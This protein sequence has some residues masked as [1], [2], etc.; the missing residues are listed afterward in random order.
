M[1]A[2]TDI[3][4]IGSEGAELARYE[5][6]SGERVLLGWRQGYGVEVVDRP[7]AGRGRGYV[8]DRGFRCP[9]QLRAFIGAYLDHAR[10]LDACPMGSDALEALVGK[11]DIEAAE[12]LLGA[13]ERC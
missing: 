7:A 10:R 2:I 5:T 1:T 13:I 11:T 9:E 6:S 4:A 8:V 3:D 12:H